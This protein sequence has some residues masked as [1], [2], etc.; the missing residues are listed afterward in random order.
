MLLKRLNDDTLSQIL[1]WL[2]GLDL[3]NCSLVRPVL[4]LLYL[5]CEI[6]LKDDS[7]LSDNSLGLQT[8]LQ[9]HKF[10][11]SLASGSGGMQGR[12]STIAIEI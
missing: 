3:F 4:R 9:S 6:V 7:A 8:A 12:I 10:I 2:G 11:S 5:P 1:G